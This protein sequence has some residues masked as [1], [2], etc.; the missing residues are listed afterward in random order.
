MDEDE[1]ILISSI[2]DAAAD[3]MAEG[4]ESPQQIKGV[5]CAVIDQYYD[6]LHAVM[7]FAEYDPALS[8]TRN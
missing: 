5:V 2:L 6:Q 1:A 8:P 7:A 4:Y 3:A